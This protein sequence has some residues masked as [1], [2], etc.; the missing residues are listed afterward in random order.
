MCPIA[1]RNCQTF[2]L[3]QSKSQEEAGEETIGPANAIQL[4]HC[5]LACV[6]ESASVSGQLEVLSVGCLYIEDARHVPNHYRRS[7]SEIRIRTA[8]L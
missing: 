4:L 6:L 5:S 7:E 3:P 2:E 1:A 8:P